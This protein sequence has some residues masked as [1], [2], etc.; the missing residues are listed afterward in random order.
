M[1]TIFIS[2][3]KIAVTSLQSLYEK[4]LQSFLNAAPGI[5]KYFNPL[6][7]EP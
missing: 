6:I 4:Q 3:R 2:N 1:N 7:P 5:K